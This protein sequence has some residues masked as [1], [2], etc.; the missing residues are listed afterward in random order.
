MS[1]ALIEKQFDAARYN[2]IS[3]TGEL[4]P[5]LQGVWGGTYVPGWAS[6]YTHNGNVPSAIAANL[7][8]NMPELTL[9][10]TSYIESLVPDM[11]LNAKHLFGARGIVLPSRTTTHGYNNALAPNFAGGMWVSGAG[12]AAHYFYDYYLHTGDRKFLADHALPFMEKA[13]LF[14]EDYLYE[15]PDGKYVFSPTTSP[16]NTPSNTDSQ[17]T[18]NATMDV[19]VAR[20]LLRN[21]IAASREL[22]RNSDKIPV[23]EE[24]LG[25]MPDYM[26]TDSGIIKEWL[27]PKLA[28][29][30]AHRH[31][32]QLYALYDGMPEEIAASPELQA[33]F[34]KSVEYK[35]KE[36]WQEDQRGFMSFGLVQ[37]GQVSTSLGEGELAYHCLKHL[38]NRFWLANLASTHNHRSLFNMDISG[39]MPAVIIKMLV[40]S[41]PGSI[42]LLPAL[43]K[44]WPK[45]SIDGVLCRGAIE[46]RHL[47]WDGKQVKATLVSAK[48]QTITLEL[49]S[50]ISELTVTSGDAQVGKGD[51]PAQR[52]VTLPA[53]EEVSLE[54]QMK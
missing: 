21:T 31:S 50:E 2:I 7:M 47:Q 8:G 40:A 20:E 49:P 33:A 22:G 18:F 9:A 42:K 6:D 25:K 15:G 37:L 10:Y 36:H 54:I 39:G 13:T 34:R 26:I 32:S 41:D 3:A 46:I 27:T 16:E 45:G 11:E 28:N 1:R 29:N 4:P 44:A 35:L 14:F 24:M 5:N 51:T 48:P 12:W 52:Q 17:A 19:S 23:W 43:P 38:V 30:D 53:G